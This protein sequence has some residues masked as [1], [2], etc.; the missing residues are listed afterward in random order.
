MRALVLAAVAACGNQPIDIQVV[1][2]GQ[3]AFSGKIGTRP[4]QRFAGIS[5]GTTTTYHLAI[6]DDFELLLGCDVATGWSAAELFGT[7]DDAVISI[8]SWNLPACTTRKTSLTGSI[9]VSGKLDTPGAVAIGD[10]TQ[11]LFSDSQGFDLG[12]VPG[13][14]DIAYTSSFIVGIAHDVELD[15]P[16]DVGT[17]SLARDG[18]SMLTNEYTPALVANEQLDAWLTLTTRNGTHMT[19][20]IG[21][22]GAAVFVPPDVMGYGDVQELHVVTTYSTGSR[23]AV[24]SGFARVA[25][26]FQ[27]LSIVQP[28]TWF[29]DSYTVR[30]Q[31]IPDFFTSV[32]ARFIENDGSG[33]ITVTASASYL[34]HRGDNLLAFDTAA[35]GFVWPLD[36]HVVPQVTVERWG[37]DLT[38][39]S[40]TIS[41]V[42]P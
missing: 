30:W 32:S 38:L 24:A 23:T 16:R 8:G 11:E 9:T 18:R 25:P 33:D 2:P 27:F 17:L 12:V 5:D 4:W 7:Y 36:D 3:P 20:T 42:A 22:L 37:S 13:T 19:W 10:Q 26:D 21:D 14:R 39:T 35:P 15:Q 41:A 6:D 40:T 34:E 31:P 1:A 28:F 29:P